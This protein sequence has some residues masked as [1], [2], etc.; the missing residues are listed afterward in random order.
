MTI[1][2]RLTLSQ[3]TDG[4]GELT[5]EVNVNGF[6]GTG[7]AWFNIGEIAVFAEA[8]GKTYPLLSDGI[9]ELKGGYWKAAA[10]GKSELEHV[11]LGM[12]FFPVGS[13][14]EV[15]LRVQLAQWLESA[16]AA[17]EYSL[18]VELRTHYEELR[19]FGR[20]LLALANGESNEA[21]LACSGAS[22]E[23]SVK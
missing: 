23:T 3:D 5:A 7:S 14:G 16:S 17:P 13:L 21:L 10:P 2:F 18:A 8:L 11:N 12:R 22:Q 9:Y 4:T 1:P 19:A 6:S 20:S 15:G